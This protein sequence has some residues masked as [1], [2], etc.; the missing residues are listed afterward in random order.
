MCERDRDN[1]CRI[2]CARCPDSLS[3]LGARRRP[4]PPAGRRRTR[5]NVIASAFRSGAVVPVLPRLPMRRELVAAGGPTARHLRVAS[6]RAPRLRRRCRLVVGRGRR[7]G[8]PPAA[9]RPADRRREHLRRRDCRPMVRSG[10]R[11]A[12][13]GWQAIARARDGQ[14]V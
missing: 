12:A 10:G 8:V 5:N 6:S 14:S 13:A 3:S 11:A 9:S 2:P 4:R 1:Y 7:R